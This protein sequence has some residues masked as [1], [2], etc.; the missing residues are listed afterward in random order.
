MVAETKDLL[1]RFP[2]QRIELPSAYRD[3]YAEHYRRNREGLSLVSSL[4]RKMETWMHR[5]VARDVFQQ[6]RNPRTLEIGAG[7]LNHLRYEPAS[8]TYDVVEERK[9]LCIESLHRGKVRNIYGSVYEIDGV[10]Y[11]RIVSIAA[12]E[13]FCNLPAVTA[14]SAMLLAADGQMRIAVPSEGTVL[15][16]LG[17]LLTSGFEFRIRY[18]LNYGVLMKHEHVNTAEEI[19]A[20]LHWFFED[21]QRIVLGFQQ[22]LSFYQFFECR[23]PIIE[24][25]RRYSGSEPPVLD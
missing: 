25:C 9:D 19:E 15:W 2:K 13:H 6:N 4:T 20:V 5:M 3:I 22:A 7:S 11:D 14:R 16:K 18:G 24:R 10:S 8:P 1:A 17:C 12:F 23:N 21:V